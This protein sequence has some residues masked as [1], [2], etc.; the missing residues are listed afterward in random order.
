MHWVFAAV[1][2]PLVFCTVSSE[3]AGVLTPSWSVFRHS[4]APVLDEIP[5]PD[6]LFVPW[7]PFWETRKR[8]QVVS[9]EVV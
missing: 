8:A 5:M 9:P 4:I 3:S 2:V 1:L 6:D 7:D